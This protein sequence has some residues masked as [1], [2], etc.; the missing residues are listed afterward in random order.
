MSRF[1]LCS[2]CF[3]PIIP[4]SRYKIDEG[5]VEHVNCLNWDKPDEPVNPKPG[6]KHLRSGP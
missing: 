5:K 3:K 4:G 1:E 2:K 6:P